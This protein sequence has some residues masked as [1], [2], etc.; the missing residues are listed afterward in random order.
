MFL[1]SWFMVQTACVCVGGG[2]GEKPGKARPP[3][4]PAASPVHVSVHTC[5]CACACVWA[6]RTR[7]APPPPSRPAPHTPPHPPRPLVPQ[8]LDS[9]PD[10]DMVAHL[11][12]L[13][14]GIMDMWVAEWWNH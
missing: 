12:M 11:P 1:L 4:L 14:D 13:L 9:V 10:L 3:L 2:G 8:V 7:R 6:A 5:A